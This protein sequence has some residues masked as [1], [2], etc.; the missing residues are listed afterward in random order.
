MPYVA[1]EVLNGES[2][3]KE[4]DIYSFGM[5]IYEVLSGLPPYYDRTHDISLATEICDGEQL[6]RPEFKIK[7]PQLLEDLVK[8]C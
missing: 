6:L 8:K 1:P 7:I 3:I 5:V 2:Y 4:A